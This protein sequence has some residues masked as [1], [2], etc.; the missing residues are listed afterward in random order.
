MSNLINPKVYISALSDLNS[1][2]NR[3]RFGVKTESSEHL[4]E[5]HSEIDARF[6]G[7]LGFG[8][9]DIDSLDRISRYANLINSEYS[10]ITRTRIISYQIKGELKLLKGARKIEAGSFKGQKIDFSHPFV[11]KLIKSHKI[12]L[13]YLNNSVSNP[14]EIYSYQE[15]FLTRKTFFQKTLLTYR[16]QDHW[17]VS[18]VFEKE[19]GGLEC[20]YF[21]ILKRK[22]R[23]SSNVL[24]LFLDFINQYCRIFKHNGVRSKFL[25]YEQSFVKNKQGDISPIDIDE[26]EMKK[27]VDTLIVGGTKYY[28][29]DFYLIIVV[30]VSQYEKELN[31]YT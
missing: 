19:K 7:K 23:E 20:N 5:L 13:P 9:K 4:G 31:S 15:S 8:I 16:N 29:Q 18:I 12:T 25:F 14:D 27:E 17:L 28:G 6:H 22:E 2:L 21:F 24:R 11:G 26:P 3:K 1:M 30:D 10:E